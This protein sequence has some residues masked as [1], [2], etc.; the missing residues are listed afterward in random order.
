[1]YEHRSSPLL[2]WPAFRA[3]VFRAGRLGLVLIAISLAVG[4]LGYRF[5]A[6]L[7][8]PDSFLNASMILAGMGP[9]GE[10]EKWKTSAKI[11]AGLYA[12]YSGLALISIAG[13]ILAPAIHRFLHKFHLE[14]QHGKRQEPG[15]DTSTK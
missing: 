2:P 8:W 5:I 11:F 12:L 4:M 14:T 3:R 7:S 13:I 6:D 9:V 15:S 10:P 1:M